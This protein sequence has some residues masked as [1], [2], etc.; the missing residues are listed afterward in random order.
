LAINFA[1]TDFST[2]TI[3]LELDTSLVP[4]FNEIDAVKLV[5]FAS[6]DETRRLFERVDSGN[7]IRSPNF[8]SGTYTFADTLFL[9]NGDG[10]FSDMASEVGLA[11]DFHHNEE[12]DR[13]IW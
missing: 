12:C 10:T 1:S 3:R 6:N 9:N 11:I 4:E 7:L 2:N 8:S 13:V 5:G